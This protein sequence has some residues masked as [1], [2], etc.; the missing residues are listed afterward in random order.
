[1]KYIQQLNITIFL[2]ALVAIGFIPRS[3]SAIM[4]SHDMELFC[5]Q[6]C[7]DPR[8]GTVLPDPFQPIS[9]IRFYIDEAD[10][11]VTTGVTEFSGR[12][13]D[14]EP[15]TIGD[16]T[17]SNQDFVGSVLSNGQRGTVIETVE[18]KIVGVDQLFSIAATQL[19]EFDFYSHLTDSPNIPGGRFWALRRREALPGG[20]SI[21][22]TVEGRYLVK[23]VPE[24]T[25]LLLLGTG[26]AGVFGNRWLC[27]RSSNQRNIHP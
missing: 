26:L 9:V 17:F 23:Q 5:V 3:T 20:G 27:R 4:I 10:I 15:F 14:Y 11:P 6:N 21:Q 24:P 1:M 19:V 13:L 16:H 12:I 2:F 18:R 8:F 22:D 25:T 7:N